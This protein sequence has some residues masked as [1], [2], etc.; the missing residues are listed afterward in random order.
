MSN[1]T[2]T[3]SVSSTSNTPS[4]VDVKV[5]KLGNRQFGAAVRFR[6][7]WVTGKGG[8]RPG[9]I[10]KMEAE[11]KKLG[12]S[13]QL[14]WNIVEGETSD[15]LVLIPIKASKKEDRKVS[16][17]NRFNDIVEATGKSSDE[18]KAAFKTAHEFA[19]ADQTQYKVRYDGK[20]KA[21]IGVTKYS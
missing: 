5:K 18:V 10:S 14:D 12:A 1:V 16:N 6:G 21:L 15:G 19:R 7:Q 2:N 11:L 17:H 4:A 20:L 3:E 9:A 13:Y 8:T